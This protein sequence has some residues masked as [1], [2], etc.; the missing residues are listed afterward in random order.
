MVLENKEY[1]KFEKAKKKITQIKS[2]YNH[3]AV[4]VIINAVLLLSKHKMTVALF[5][6]GASVHPK[7]M[8]W[9]EWNIY[10]WGAGLLIHAIFVFGRVPFFVKKWEERQIKKYMNENNN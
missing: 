1:K 10:I 8:N 3:A 5:G 7:A 9:I 2:F 4:F 6:E